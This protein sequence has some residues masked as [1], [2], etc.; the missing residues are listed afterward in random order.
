MSE[1]E[2]KLGLRPRWESFKNVCKDVGFILR[3]EVVLVG[4]ETSLL[5]QAQSIDPLTGQIDTR[6]MVEEAV[7]QYLECE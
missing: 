4:V 2:A 5:D 7:Q 6:G 1:A 3:G